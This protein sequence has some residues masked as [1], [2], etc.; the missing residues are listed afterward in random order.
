MC[1]RL[2]N[3]AGRQWMLVGLLVGLGVMECQP[4]TAQEELVKTTVVYREVEGHKILADVYRPQG[5]DV[6]PVVVWLHGGALV[7][8]NREYIHSEVRALAEENEYA[9]VSFD[10]RLAPETKL[11]GIIS[12][13]EAALAWLAHEGASQFHLDPDRIVV[14]GQSAG[15]YLTLVTGYRAEP[16]PRALVALFGYG[17]LTADWY[18]TPSPHPAHNPRV[19]TTEEAASLTDGTVV[20]D[21]R[22]RIGDGLS[23]YLHYRQAGTWPQEV[24]GFDNST[25]V[26]EL[27]PFEPVRHVTSDYPPTL[28]VH[29]TGDTDVPF[30]ESVMMADQLKRHGVPVILKLIDN[31]EH[32]F[33]GG[34]PAQIDDA[35]Q[36]MREFLAQH[37]EAR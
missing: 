31:G 16:K 10:Y 34:D 37:L 36:T 23:L 35:Y 18:F 29:G 24:G 11:P 8:W 27:A 21:D 30:E 15:G 14:V 13:I 1:L 5:H 3:H 4:A 2:G 17:S 33:A 9:L 25:M 32:E 6:L 28:L 7:F 22:D 20:S 19:I 26:R 12:D